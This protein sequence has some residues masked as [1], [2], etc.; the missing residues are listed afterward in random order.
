MVIELFIA[1]PLGAMQCKAK[2]I[3]ACASG[4]TLS[5]WTNRGFICSVSINEHK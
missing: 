3:K 1:G 4:M 5:H 2:Q